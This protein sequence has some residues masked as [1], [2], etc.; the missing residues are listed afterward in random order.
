M[1]IL[2][3]GGAGYIGSHTVRA[4]IHAGFTPIVVDN[5]SRGHCNAIPSDVKVIE[6]DIANPKI[7]NVLR[8][9]NIKG[10]MHFAAHSQVGESMINPSIYYEN[11]VVGSYRLIELARQA[12]VQYFV[13]SSTAAVYGE[14]EVV[15]I[16]ETS[17]LQPTNVYGRTKLM[18]EDMLHDYSSI[19]GST[20]VALRY[21]NAAGADESGEIGEDHSPETHLIPL[22]L[23]TALGKRPHITVF[24]TDY[25]TIDGTCIR[26]YIHV[27]DLA[28]AHV[29]A[30]N[31]LVGGGESRVFNLGS[32]NGFSVKDIIDTAKNVTGINIPVEYGE[33][34]KGDPSTL[35]ASSD[36][37][38]DI[39]GWNPKH[40]ELSQIISD[41][42]RWHR[43]HPSGYDDI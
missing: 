18:I 43:L 17:K 40:S 16:V 19:Y 30:M 33:R 11:N 12:G 6:L 21:F 8:D 7:I 10:I 4:L 28:S 15:P 39:L 41:A 26:D 24:G 37:I 13:F 1:N 29:L 5:F 38:K 14:P 22:V 36:C 35:I 9:N 25:D 3:T 42:W 2:V 34:R 31:Y 23:E 20:Y 27:T 32:G